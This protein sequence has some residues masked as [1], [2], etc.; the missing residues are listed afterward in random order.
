[1]KFSA[2]SQAHKHAGN[3]PWTH[4]VPGTLVFHSFPLVSRLLAAERL[5]IFRKLPHLFSFILYQFSGVERIDIRLMFQ[6]FCCWEFQAQWKVFPVQTI[7]QWCPLY[8]VKLFLLAMEAVYL[9]PGL[10]K[11]PATKIYFVIVIS[12]FWTIQNEIHYLW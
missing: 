11:F 10:K 8:S 5:S 2:Y 7:R 3:R 12:A 9:K 1:M 6:I 4:P